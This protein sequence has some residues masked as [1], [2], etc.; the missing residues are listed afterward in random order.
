MDGQSDGHTKLTVQ[1]N[2]RI[3]RQTDK[4]NCATKWKDNRQTD[5]TNCATKWKD[6]QTD[7]QN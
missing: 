4:T 5:K 1:P 6:K 3:N 2:G 7:R